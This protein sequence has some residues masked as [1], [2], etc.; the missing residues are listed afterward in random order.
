M[1]TIKQ[2]AQS[3]KKSESAL[4]KQ[5]EN[6]FKVWVNSYREI[7]L[8]DSKTAHKELL[9]TL[10]SLGLAPKTVET[11]L[12]MLRVALKHGLDL[13]QFTA[14][15]QVETANKQVKQGTAKSVNGELVS[16]PETSEA[17]NVADAEMIKAQN[18]NEI[19]A[20]LNSAVFQ[21]F[22]KEFVK[23]SWDFANIKKALLKN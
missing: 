14:F 6:T 8:F 2:L 18:D 11:R 16:I 1:K 10:V 12:S 5:S 4:A 13:S 21:S 19:I 22:K 17:N 3:I 7:Q 15:Q 20:I 9:T 23:N